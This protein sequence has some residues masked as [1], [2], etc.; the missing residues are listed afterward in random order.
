MAL[1]LTSVGFCLVRGLPVVAEFVVDQKVFT[2][3]HISA[4][5]HKAAS[6]DRRG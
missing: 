6:H 5:S 4:G 3:R 2:P 1:V